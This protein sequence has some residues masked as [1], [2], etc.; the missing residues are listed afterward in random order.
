MGDVLAAGVGPVGDVDG[1]GERSVVE[2]EVGRLLAR[3]GDA[4][5]HGQGAL[6]GGGHVV[7]A[8]TVDAGVDPQVG[9]GGVDD[10]FQRVEEVVEA[11]QD[12]AVRLGDRPAGT[13]VVAEADLGR[14]PAAGIGQRQS[15]VDLERQGR[16]AEQV[17]GRDALDLDVGGEDGPEVGRVVEDAVDVD[18]VHRHRHIGQDVAV[19]VDRDRRLGDTGLADGQV[20]EAGVVGAGEGVDGIDRDGD[21]Y[22][23]GRALRRQQGQRGPRTRAGDGQGRERAPSQPASPAGRFGGAVGVAGSAADLHGFRSSYESGGGRAGAEMGKV[24]LRV[25]AT[26]RA[27]GSETLTTLENLQFKMTRAHGASRPSW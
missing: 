13:G 7:E 4:A 9:A 24:A 19:D 14:G 11:A 1:F 21:R 17:G 10:C 26:S 3:H 2:A 20:E 22:A 18:Q 12:R 16:L 5:Q 25:A 23:V 15:D 27:S 6:I 8:E